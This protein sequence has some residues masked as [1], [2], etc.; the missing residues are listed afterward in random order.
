MFYG[1]SFPSKDSFLSGVSLC[2]GSRLG[3]VAWRRWEGLTVAGY[4]EGLKPVM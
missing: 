4:S 1:L 2:G 3:A